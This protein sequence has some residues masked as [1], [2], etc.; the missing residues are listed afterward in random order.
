MRILQADG[1]FKVAFGPFTAEIW[2]RKD[3][4]VLL[5]DSTLG[6]FTSA[7]SS[8]EAMAL[9]RERYGPKLEEALRELHEGNEDVP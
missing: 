3:G 4:S 9:V 2:P 7:A 5:I 1:H 6:I 8:S